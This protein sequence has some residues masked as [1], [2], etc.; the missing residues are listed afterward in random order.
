MKR[1]VTRLTRDLGR[2]LNTARQEAGLSTRAAVDRMPMR[3]KISHTQLVSYENGEA[4]VPIDVLSLLATI[5][6]RPLNWFLESS[7][8]LCGFRYRN[9]KSRVGVKDKRQFEAMASKWIDAYF[10]LEE[11]LHC[12]LKPKQ[13]SQGLAVDSDTDPVELAVVVRKSLELKDSEPVTDIIDGVLHAF[14]VRVIEADAKIEIDGVAAK[15]GRDFVVVLNRETTNDRLRMNAAHE[16][17]HA[18]Y[19]DCKNDQGWSDDT[20]EK[21]AY[22]FGSHLLLPER[23][24]E[25]AFEGQSFIR[26]IEFKKKFGISLAAMIYRAE[27]SKV[28][29]STTARRLWMEMSQRGWRKIEPGHVWRERAVRFEV[30]LDSAIR[31]KKLTWEEAESVTGITQEELVL[32]LQEASG[33]LHQE[34]KEGGDG[35]KILKLFDQE[36]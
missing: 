28:I 11:R 23:A 14:G 31:S 6:S 1:K 18:L 9:I 10:Q 2:R 26:L 25:K 17:A 36:S 5:Y 21:R 22:E 30:L 20:V 35:P 7:E 34:D 15:R 29:R 3:S 32:R 33:V 19:D 16:L 27:K 12:P 24:L 4:S 8:E 13:W